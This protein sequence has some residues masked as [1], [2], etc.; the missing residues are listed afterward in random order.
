MLIRYQALN[1]HF[2]NNRDMVTIQDFR[3]DSS[4]IPFQNIIMNLERIITE[5]YSFSAI[6]T[7]ACHCAQPLPAPDRQVRGGKYT[8]Q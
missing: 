1:M 7:Q 5:R 6:Q 2:A 4:H 3:Y 8:S